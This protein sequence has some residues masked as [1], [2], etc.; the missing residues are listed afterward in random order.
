[1]TIYVCQSTDAS[2]PVLNGTAGSLL[3]VLDKVLVDGYG[4]HPGLGWTIAYTDTNKRAYRMPAGSS[5][6]YLRVVDDGSYATGRAALIQAFDAMTDIDTG[7]GPIHPAGAIYWTKSSTSDATA[8]DWRLVS[9]GAFLHF[10]PRWSSNASYYASWYRFGDIVRANELPAAELTMVDGTSL[11]GQSVPG[12]NEG[13][14]TYSTTT[15]HGLLP[16]ADGSIARGTY[17]HATN[18]FTQSAA[19]TSSWPVPQPNGVG[20][21]HGRPFIAAHNNSNTAQQWLAGWFPGVLVPWLTDGPT[22]DGD[23]TDDVVGHAGDFLQVAWTYNG[24]NT[25]KVLIDTVGPWR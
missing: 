6:R 25:A 16:Q 21:L 13:S 8:R 11:A 4:S 23:I 14:A 19:P 24:S 5:Q 17:Y 18:P 2:A 12:Q 3:D 1:M 15:L 9:D 22:G 7:T 20:Q 10:F